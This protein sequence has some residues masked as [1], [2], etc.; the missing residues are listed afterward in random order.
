MLCYT[1]YFVRFLGSEDAAKK[2]FPLNHVFDLLPHGAD[3]EVVDLQYC[4][5][6]SAY[7]YKVIQ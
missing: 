7:I 6:Y 3:G 4:C 2:N 5:A 1:A